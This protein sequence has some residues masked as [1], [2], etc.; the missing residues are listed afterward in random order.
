MVLNV[1]FGKFCEC[2]KWMSPNENKIPVT[3]KNFN[4]NDEQA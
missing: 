1:C 2:T 3:I 4:L